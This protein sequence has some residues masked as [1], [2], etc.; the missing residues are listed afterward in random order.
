VPR[1]SP[2][3]LRN[4]PPPASPRRSPRWLLFA[5]VPLALFA[6]VLFI[7]SGAEPKYK[8]SPLSLWV[9][10]YKN[11]VDA[12][13][14]RIEAADAIHTIGTNALPA[15][16]RW[17]GASDSKF[18]LWLADLAGKQSLINFTFHDASDYHERAETVFDLLGPEGIYAVP[19]LER[20]MDNLD[21][22]E[23]AI[24]ILCALGQDSLPALLRGLTNSNPAIRSATADGINEYASTYFWAGSRSLL[25]VLLPNDLLL[26]MLNDPEPAC[27]L[28]A[29]RGLSEAAEYKLIPPAQA[30][31]LLIKAAL[32]DPD[33]DCWHQAAFALGEFGSAATNAVPSLFTIL[34]GNTNLEAEGCV[35]VLDSLQSIGIEKP[36]LITAIARQLASSRPEVRI[37]AAHMLTGY[38]PAAQPAIPLLIKCLSDADSRNAALTA[39]CYVGTNSLI[40]I[41]ALEQNLKLPDPPTRIWA[42]M[43]LGEFGP[44]AKPSIPAL[45]RAAIGQNY[46]V[47]NAIYHALQDIDPAT[48][49]AKAKAL[50]V[51]FL[52]PSIIPFLIKG[53]SHSNP[54]IRRASADCLGKFG[55]DASAAVPELLTAL[56][57]KDETVR[58]AA[59]ESLKAI[60]PRAVAKIADK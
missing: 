1:T 15:A 60:D 20:L 53:L 22:A 18:K 17:L 30:V 40:V 10:R 2:A 39:L 35:R 45:L 42:A 38:G 7:P 21:S 41:P 54:A 12:D 47:R 52:D 27:R 48:A 46:D 51:D 43:V 5:L 57:D 13:P 56:A 19:L 33:A 6:L 32:H 37:W 55:P 36:R 49:A 16:V 29:A 8:G 59:L 34:A 26:Q 28:L 31:P 14:E 24:P 23:R 50:D 44:K 9:E 3:P 4:P 25:P 58:A 11:F